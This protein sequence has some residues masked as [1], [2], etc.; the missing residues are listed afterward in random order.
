MV[1]FL[2]GML[3]SVGQ[4]LATTLRPPSGTE[5]SQH[6]ESRLTYGTEGQPA[7]GTRMYELRTSSCNKDETLCPEAGPSGA[8]GQ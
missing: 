5:G 3:G 4:P 1:V 2:G 7:F 6:P 8:Q